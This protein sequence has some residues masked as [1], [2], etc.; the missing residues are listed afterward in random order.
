MELHTHAPKTHDLANRKTDTLDARIIH[1]H[2]QGVV[3]EDI[4]RALF[5]D[6]CWGYGELVENG[7]IYLSSTQKK[8]TRFRVYVGQVVSHVLKQKVSS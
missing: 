1:L 3:P 4:V 8:L 6:G 5:S 2:N 7:G